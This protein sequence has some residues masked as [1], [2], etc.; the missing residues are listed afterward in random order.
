[1]QA[2]VELMRDESD[3]EELVEAVRAFVEAEIA[4]TVGGLR[5]ALTTLDAVLARLAGHSRDTFVQ[6]LV[7][8]ARAQFE[9][10]A[11]RVSELERVEAAAGVV[12]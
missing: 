10:L 8:A 5:L 9:E 4:P 3:S 11:T 12:P 1:M 6:L 7:A 2:N